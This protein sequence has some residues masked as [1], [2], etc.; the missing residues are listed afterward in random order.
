M[1]QRPNAVALLVCEQTIVQEK[2]HN[3]TLV[4]HFSRRRMA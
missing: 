1:P 2:T 3:V 4:N